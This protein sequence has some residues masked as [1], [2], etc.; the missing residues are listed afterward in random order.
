MEK[1][2]GPMGTARA[3]AF[4]GRC[5]GYTDLSSATVPMHICQTGTQ[6]ASTHRVLAV[7][8]IERGCGGARLGSVG[9]RGQ[10]SRMPGG[11]RKNDALA[12]WWADLL[13][14]LLEPIGPCSWGGKQVLWPIWADEMIYRNYTMLQLVSLLATHFESEHDSS[15]CFRLNSKLGVD[16]TT[17]MRKLVISNDSECLPCS[18][19][20][21]T[22]AC[23]LLELFGPLLG[24]IAI[25]TRIEPMRLPAYRR[26]A[27]ALIG[28]DLISLMLIHGICDLEE[29]SIQVELVR[30]SRSRGRFAIKHGGLRGQIPMSQEWSQIG[31][32][33]ASL[34]ETEIIYRGSPFGRSAVE[35]EFPI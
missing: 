10:V 15:F 20:L 11:C 35:V 14:T 23:T 30:I 3:Y 22:I 31:Q 8:L 27:L 9:Q 18:A 13:P 29:A 26:R 5:D 19:I 24:N 12:A 25:K 32:D 21:R 4:V 28:F 34:L 7:P 16:L 6:N 2:I 33:L 17:S 1:V